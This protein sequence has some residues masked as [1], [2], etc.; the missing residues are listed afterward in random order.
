MELTF[1]EPLGLRIPG[2]PETIEKNN[3]R[4]CSM[5]PS[6]PSS[7]QEASKASQD[8]EMK[9]T[10][11]PSSCS[12]S[13]LQIN[14]GLTRTL[15]PSI[16]ETRVLRTAITALLGKRAPEPKFDELTVQKRPTKRPRP[17][18]R[19]LVLPPVPFTRFAPFLLNF[20]LLLFFSGGNLIKPC[21]H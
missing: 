4:G 20:L 18:S 2:S 3:T 21:R 17:H 12:P 16:S 6:H 14:S 13:P 15:S 5:Q 10:Q 9:R 1:G 19:S 11:I 7:L 8:V